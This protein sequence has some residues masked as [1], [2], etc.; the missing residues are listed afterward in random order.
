MGKRQQESDARAAEIL[1]TH[2]REEAAE[3]LGMSE[4]SL[5][6][7]ATRLRKK[8]IP[9]DRLKPGHKVS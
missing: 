2:T 9:V 8:R 4:R 6:N 5:R 3:L 1:N 7:L